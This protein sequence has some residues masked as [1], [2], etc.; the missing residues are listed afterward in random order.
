MATAALLCLKAARTLV[1]REVARNARK[2][3]C[4]KW[5]CLYQH[6]SKSVWVRSIQ[7]LLV[8][9]HCYICWWRCL[10]AGAVVMVP[11][12]RF[13]NV[14]CWDWAVA[15]KELSLSWR[16]S[17][18]YAAQCHCCL[19]AHLS[20]PICSSQSDGSFNCSWKTSASLNFLPFSLFSAFSLFPPHL[21]LSVTSVVRF[22]WFLLLSEGT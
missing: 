15:W 1:C 11:T 8:C 6:S 9:C 22:L 17:C 10:R 13:R 20:T 12:A 16:R 14:T 2:R 7:C 19:T 5:K 21:F 4:L 18:C 3:W